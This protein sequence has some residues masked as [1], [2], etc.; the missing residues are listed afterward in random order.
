M[1]VLCNFAPGEVYARGALRFSRPPLGVAGS[2]LQGSARR[3]GACRLRAGVVDLSAAQR[4]PG[5]AVPGSAAVARP[6]VGWASRP[7]GPVPGLPVRSAS[8]LRRWPGPFGS[9]AA[10]LRRP[11]LGWLVWRTIG[12]RACGPAPP[13]FGLAPPSAGGWGPPPAVGVRSL[14][15]GPP[16]RGGSSRRC[17]PFRPGSVGAPS[18]EIRLRAG[19][20][21]S[22][23]PPGER[24]SRVASG[25]SPYPRR[26]VA[27]QSFPGG[28]DK[29]PE[30]CYNRGVATE[31]RRTPGDWLILNPGV[32]FC[33]EGSKSTGISRCHLGLTG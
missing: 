26:N 33:Y 22:R 16:S 24:G 10:C 3:A 8:L 1:A 19:F 6:P 31:L 18:P 30:M 12:P 9:P 15:W 21:P 27:S 20:S 23:P 28:L 14:A 7:T 4:G 13:A 29:G 32:F 17:G 25:R 11:C 5:P 2:A